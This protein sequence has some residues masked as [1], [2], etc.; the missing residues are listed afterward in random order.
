MVEQNR[1]VLFA[2]INDPQTLHW[3]VEKLY[4][5]YAES[6]QIASALTSAEA[7]AAFSAYHLQDT[8]VALVISNCCKDGTF[9]SQITWKAQEL[10]PGVRRVLLGEFTEKQVLVNALSSQAADSYLTLPINSTDDELYP[11]VD[12]LLADW[13][14]G[15]AP[16]HKG[17]RIVGYRYSARGHRMKN[18]LARNLIPYRW[19]EVDQSAEARS[20]LQTAG[21]TGKHFPVVFLPDGSYLVQPQIPQLAERVGLQQQAEYRFYDLV[22]V[23]GGP[24]GLSAAVYGASEGLHTLMIEAEAPGGQAG[25]SSRIENYL[26]FPNGLSG[27]ELTRRAVAQAIRF[28][29]EILTPQEATGIRLK[30]H[31]RI[32]Q[33]ADGSEVACHVLLVATGVSYRRL[34]I[35]G[36]EQLTG[37]GVYYGTV[38]TEVLTCTNQEVIILGGG[39]S[40]GQSAIYLSRF[41]SQVT[42]V[43]IEDSLARTMSQYL[44]DQIQQAENIQVRYR[45]TVA[46]LHGEAHLEQVTL[47]NEA[48]GVQETVPAAALFI[49]IGMTPR[50]DWLNGKMACDDQGYILTGA[51]VVRAGRAEEFERFGREPSFLESSIPGIFIAGDTRHGSVKRIAS[52][53]G[54]GAMAVNLIHQYLAG[55]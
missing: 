55:L 16:A 19:L 33:L 35:A 12:D 1:P 34:N 46:G 8:A 36:E 14:A 53:V 52:G 49:Y 54:E 28:G 37:R 30:G 25:Q 13:K 47:M 38:V 22:V 45:S 2:V 20:L 17:V 27:A 24:A 29:V 44:I 48:S 32:V 7:Y 50:T 51:D 40:A 6:F 26:G 31:Y 11:V 39:N 4:F 42:M 3:V 10:F 41:A 21:L 5:R 15:A 18:F 43:T 9:D 23:G